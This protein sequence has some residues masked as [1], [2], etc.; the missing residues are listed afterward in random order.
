MAFHRTTHWPWKMAFL[1]L[2]SAGTSPCLA[3]KMPP[4]RNDQ[5]DHI[6]EKVINAGK[7]SPPSM[8]LR[9]SW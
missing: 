3:R 9:G 5:P 4:C 2:V 6:T 8:S 1:T 7:S